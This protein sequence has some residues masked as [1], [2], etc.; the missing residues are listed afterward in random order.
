MYHI[1]A[2]NCAEAWIKATQDILDKGMNMGGLYEI[3]NM[4]IEIKSSDVVTLAGS[5]PFTDFCGVHSGLGSINSCK[6]TE[7][8]TIHLG[9]RH[10]P[11]Y[12]DLDV[13]T[14]SQRVTLIS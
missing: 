10:Q 1:T 3:L 6:I 9:A 8:A 4:G 5:G 12:H 13:N 2:N 11:L 14:Q 7:A